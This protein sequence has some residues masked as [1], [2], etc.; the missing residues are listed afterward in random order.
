MR[1]QK[2]RDPQ[3]SLRQQK[4]EWVCDDAFKKGAP[5]MTAAVSMSVPLPS[6]HLPPHFP[7]SSSLRNT[8]R[9]LHQ[10][11]F[12]PISHKRGVYIDGHERKDMVKYRS[13]FLSTS[14]M[15]Q[16]THQAPPLCS[17]E[18]LYFTAAQQ[19]PAEELKDKKLV[20]IFHNESLLHTAPT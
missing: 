1:Q 4:F 20:T 6:H 7:R 13:E 19:P 2:F 3:S 12:K 11:A 8:V 14:K 9:W 17:G 16:G 10:L 18:I 5:N 15:L